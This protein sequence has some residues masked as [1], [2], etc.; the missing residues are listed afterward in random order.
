[1]EPVITPLVTDICFALCDFV[2]MVGERVVDAAAVKVKVLTEVLHANTGA[3]DVP[4]GVTYAPR[5]V[6]LEFLVVKLG[7]CEPEYKVSLVFLVAVFFNAF[8]HAD[9]EVFLTE[10]VENIILL[11]F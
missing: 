8:T 1:M 10:I 4:A 7:L 11:E 2:C 3:L 6:P 9:F 5:A